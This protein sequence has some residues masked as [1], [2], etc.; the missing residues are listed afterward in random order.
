MVERAHPR[1]HLLGKQVTF[2]LHQNI[3][4]NIVIVITTL[5][6][7]DIHVEER[8]DDIPDN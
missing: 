1:T 8:R 7:H 5:Q 6:K 4:G 2:T 3:T